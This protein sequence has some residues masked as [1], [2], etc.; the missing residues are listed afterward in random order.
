MKRIKAFDKYVGQ[1]RAAAEIIASDPA[2]YGGIMAAWAAAVLEGEFPMIDL[3]GD[4]KHSGSAHAPLQ[5]L[6]T[7]LAAPNSARAAEVPEV[8]DQ[9][10]EQGACA[11]DPEKAAGQSSWLTPGSN[12]RSSPTPVETRR[13]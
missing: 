8:Q 9:V 3:L 2:R 13:R 6:P 10:V 5:P 1:N 4:Q 7:R 11:E 12:L